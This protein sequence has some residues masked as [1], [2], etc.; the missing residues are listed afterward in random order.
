MQ[1]DALESE[2]VSVHGLLVGTD[3]HAKRSR[4]VNAFFSEQREQFGESPVVDVE[5]R[6]VAVRSNPVGMLFT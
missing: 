1:Q 3:S 6:A 5:G 2:I 4:M